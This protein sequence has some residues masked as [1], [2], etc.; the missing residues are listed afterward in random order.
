MSSL[1]HFHRG[2]VVTLL[3]CAD[4]RPPKPLSDAAILWLEDHLEDDF[5]AARRESY[6]PEHAAIL[7]EIRVFLTALW[8]AKRPT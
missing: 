8:E 3:T 1:A 7:Q 4:C 2:S 6:G 5:Q